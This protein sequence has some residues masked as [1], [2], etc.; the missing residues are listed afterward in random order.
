VTRG[1]GFDNKRRWKEEQHPSNTWFTPEWLLERIRPL[2][3]GSIDLDPC[4]VPENPTGAERFYTRHDDG[5]LQPWDAKAIFCNPPFGPTLIHWAEKCATAHAAGAKVVL[6]VSTR[7]ETGWFQAA[8]RES[9]TVLFLSGRLAF[10][11]L[12]RHTAMPCTLFGFGVDL[13]PLNDLGCVLKP[14]EEAA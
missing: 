10:Q 14:T 8:L 2:L 7:P 11:G 4:T 3:G 13:S 6:L 9:D 1:F 5:I 12:D